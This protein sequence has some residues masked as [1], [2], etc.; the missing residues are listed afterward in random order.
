[1]LG[2]K[3]QSGPERRNMRLSRTARIAIGLSALA[4]T[5]A[6]AFEIS[7]TAPKVHFTGVNNSAFD[8]A[9]KAYFETK[10]NGEVETAFN[11]TLVD[12][13]TKMKGFKSQK[14]LAQAMAN[15]NVYSANSATLQ[16][17]QN[18]SLFAVSTGFMLGVQ[19]PSLD[20]KAYESMPEDVKEKGDIYLGVGAGFT[21]L[22]VG[23]NCGKFLLPNLYLNLKYGGMS[24][25]LGDVSMD[26]KVMGV[27]ASYAILQ[28]KSLIGLV[29]WRGI[30]ASTGFYMQMDKI[31]M[32]IEPDTFKTDAHF[33]QAVLAGATGQ[34]ST[35]KAA[36]LN[37]MGYGPSNPDAQ[38]AIAPVFNMGLDVSTYT[39]PLEVNTAVALLWGVININAGVGVDL[40]F[41]N[42]KVDLK[43]NSDASIEETAKVT[44]DP[45]EVNVAGSSSNGPSF[46]RP[47]V[48]TG[49]GLGLG[50]VKIDVPL[51]YYFNSGLALGITAAVVW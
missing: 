22:N 3:V 2:G 39:I 23:I 24:T 8:A 6:H 45:A 29:K 43:G 13:N 30:S 18:Y 46:L 16:G 15:A 50:P 7:G 28:P 38:V 33:R 10:M 4:S 5:A 35:D 41:G 44:F 49:V 19:A 34:D 48:M 21:Y 20:P 37:E 47:R 12:A 1:M 14:D 25:D 31:N 40:N 17:Y 32:T 42:A 11:S 36:I 9:M 27:G 51:L 26:F